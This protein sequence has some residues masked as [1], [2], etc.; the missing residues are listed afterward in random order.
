MDPG[1]V[2][3]YSMRGACH[4]GLGDVK[5]A[6]ADFSSAVAANAKDAHA[7]HMLG[8][9]QTALGHFTA[10]A[11]TFSKLLKGDGGHC[12]YYNREVA[13]YYWARLDASLLTY[14]ADNELSATLK[15]AQCKRADPRLIKGSRH[16]Y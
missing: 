5:A 7:R 16:S 6:A 11:A 8:V 9:C 13:A 14:N 3:A 4:H 15:E 12:G 1:Y 2:Q 10:A